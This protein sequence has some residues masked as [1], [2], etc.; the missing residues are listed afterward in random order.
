MKYVKGGGLLCSASAHLGVI[1]GVL[2]AALIPR[3]G[4]SSLWPSS[5]SSP[6]PLLLLLLF[7]FFFF[8]SRAVTETEKII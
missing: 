1:Q 8:F 6:L 4:R 7:V 2:A 5:V 3:Q